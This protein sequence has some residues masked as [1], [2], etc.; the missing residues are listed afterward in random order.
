M[1][2]VRSACWI[3]PIISEALEKARRTSAKPENVRASFHIDVVQHIISKYASGAF[4]IAVAFAVRDGQEFPVIAVGSG[5]RSTVAARKELS[6]SDGKSLI[7][8]HA[9]YFRTLNASGVPG[10]SPAR[11]SDWAD[12][13][14]ICFENREA[15]IGRFLRRHLGAEGASSFIEL[16][17]GK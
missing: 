9:V 10:S 6:S 11:Y 5:V 12:I 8:Q 15:N 16:A 1:S 13:V 17:S 3:L 4:E 14:Q 2:A 7:R